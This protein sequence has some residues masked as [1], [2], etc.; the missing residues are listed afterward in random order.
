MLAT[1]KVLSLSAAACLGGVLALSSAPAHAW[2]PTRPVEFIIPAGT[3][4]GADIWRASSRA[5]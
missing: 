1:N 2:E 5:S 4:G 3:G